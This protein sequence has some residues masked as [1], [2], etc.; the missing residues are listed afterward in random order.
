MKATALKLWSTTALVA[1]LL[2]CGGGGGGGTASSV[3]TPVTNT[4]PV[5]SA[6][7][8]Q[9]VV[10]NAIVTLD[11]SASTDSN[12]DPL[13]YSWTLSAKPPG[14]AAALINPTSVKPTF[15]ADSAGTYTATL[16]VN[17]GKVNSNPFTVN[18]AVSVDNAAP[19]AN[20]GI[21][22][23]VVAGSAVI[24]DGSASSDANKDTL[25]FSWTLTAKPI[26]S[27]ATLIQPNS[28]KPSFTVD[29][30][31]IYVA[32]LIVNDGKVNSNTASVSV[33]SNAAPT[34]LS[35]TSPYIAFPTLLDL[36]FRLKNADAAKAILANESAFVAA[37]SNDYGWQMRA[38]Y[39]QQ[40][41]FKVPVTKGHFY[42]FSS[43]SYWGPCLTIYDEAGY[44]LLR[45]SCAPPSSGVSSTTKKLLVVKTGFVYI[46]VVSQI[47]PV[48][49]NA[50]LV[51]DVRTNTLGSDSGGTT[52][53]STFATG[54]FAD[55]ID[56]A[57]FGGAGTD[58]VI[59]KTS[60]NKTVFGGEGDDSIEIK[61]GTYSSTFF[62]GGDGID[63]AV[64]DF[65]SAGISLKRAMAFGW[66]LS[67]AGTPN[68][69]TEV[70]DSHDIMLGANSKLIKVRN[71]ERIQFT[72]K[73]LNVSAL[74]GY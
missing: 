70:A 65:S 33:T 12:S 2:A 68:S 29:L 5:A 8:D 42:Q 46:N 67:V 23:N 1:G 9:S 56:V 4:A 35:S 41:L 69:A 39:S 34:P 71:V 62:D 16:V 54:P 49:K 27:A 26:G 6:G 43:S 74:P 44:D 50:D 22:Q 63:T 14:S 53:L 66:G 37:A 17:D 18:I 40:G 64:L 10:A 47:S 59:A 52:D 11:G 60:G 38:T 24:L 20:A 51:I 28:I 55:Q 13:T 15:A 21:A 57:F 48:F 58:R 36:N 61:S 72:D 73:L 30:T 7:V 3:P 32:A 45:I 19:V 31:G 25:S